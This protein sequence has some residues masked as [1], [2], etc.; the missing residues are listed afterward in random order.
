MASLVNSVISIAGI[1]VT[2]VKMLIRCTRSCD[3][4]VVPCWVVITCV[5]CVFISL[6]S[7]RTQ[8][9]L[10]SSMSCSVASLDA[11]FSGFT[12]VQAVMVSSGFSMVS[13]SFVVF[14]R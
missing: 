10:V 12:M 3:L 5:S 14:R 6:I 13:V 4:V 7:S 1:S 9:R 2:L 8:T 11:A